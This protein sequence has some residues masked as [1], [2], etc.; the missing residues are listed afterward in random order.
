MVLLPCRHRILCR[1]PFHLDAPDF[2]TRILRVKLNQL[3]SFSGVMLIVSQ[4]VAVHAV[5]SVKNAQFAVSLL[6]SAY[7]YMMFSFNLS[8]LFFIKCTNWSP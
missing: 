3:L 2:L 7:L 4:C 8:C 1:W 6:R 5:R